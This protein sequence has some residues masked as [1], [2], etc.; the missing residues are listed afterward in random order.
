MRF[1]NVLRAALVALGLSLAGQAVPAA[2]MT[3]TWTQG[4]WY[5]PLT[6]AP[7]AGTLV[8]TVT[9]T[10]LQPDGIL[11]NIAGNSAAPVDLVTAARITWT[12]PGAFTLDPTAVP[13][14]FVYAY[15]PSAFNLSVGD[16]SVLVIDTANQR[17]VFG[18]GGPI[19]GFGRLTVDGTQFWTFGPIVTQVPAPAGLALFG[20]GLV[21]LTLAARRRAA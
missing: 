5:D 12:G 18:S 3:I 10:D 15:G 20:L 16:G 13:F 6:S 8:F 14:E 21:A 19:G 9:A 2:A 4:D 1:K 17:E 11:T 7:V